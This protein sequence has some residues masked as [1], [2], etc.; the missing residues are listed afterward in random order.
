MTAL[1]IDRQLGMLTG[2][3]IVICF[4]WILMNLVIHLTGRR[5]MT[6]I[7]IIFPLFIYFGYIFVRNL[8]LYLNH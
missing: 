4:A 6:W 2:I 1:E 5:K 3:F 7:R 8:F